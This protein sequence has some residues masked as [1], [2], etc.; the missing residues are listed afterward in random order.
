MHRE[1]CALSLSS[2]NSLYTSFQSR[3]RSS[4]GRRSKPTRAISRNP[5]G[6]PMLYHCERLC[7]LLLLLFEYAPIIERHNFYELLPVT[8]PIVQYGLCTSAFGQFKVPR[9][10]VTHERFFL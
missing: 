4:T 6:L 10:Q 5:V 3:T 9:D 8:R 7:R 2:E 1:A